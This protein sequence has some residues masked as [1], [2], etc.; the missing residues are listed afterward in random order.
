VTRMT[1]PFTRRRCGIGLLAAL[2][3]SPSPLV[4]QRAPATRPQ[5]V[6]VLVVD[7]MRAD[8][9]DRFQRDWSAGLKRV[10]T[11]GA[12]FTNVAYP[13]LATYT[14][15]GH[16]TIA[17]GTF[18]HL[19]G[20][21]QNAWYDRERGGNMTCTDDPT[22]QGVSYGG[23]ANA[24]GPGR[25]RV[26]TL[27]DT[28]RAQRSSRVVSLAIK[29]RSAIMLAGHGGD[30]V[31]WMPEEDD[32]WQTSTAFS[33][34]PN[35]AMK[36]YVEANRIEAD[37]GK[38][39][40]RTLPPARYPEVDDGEAEAP[41]PGWTTAFPH[42]L[43]D[44]S[45]APGKQFYTLWQHS[46][47]A[48]EYVG[49]MAAS[50]AETLQLGQRGTTDLLAISFSSPDLVGHQ[51][52]PNSQEIRDM[53]VRLDRTIGR[54]LKRLD[55][56]LGRDG[57]VVAVSADH[58]VAEIPEQ[59][60]RRGLNAGRLTSRSVNELVQRTVEAVF[61]PG[62]YA[63]RVTTNDVYF[64]PG[65]Y[66]RL[67]REP[68]A[69]EAVE[70]ALTS[71]P[72]IVRVLRAEQLEGSIHSTDPVVRAAALSYVPGRSGDMVLVTRPRWMFSTV[73]TT[74][75]SAT[76]ADQRVPLAFM[77]WGIRPGAYADAATPA[78]L[79]PTLAALVGVSMPTAEGRA[80][81]AALRTPAAH[82]QAGTP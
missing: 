52:G 8:Y 77:G 26:P 23:H 72:G 39:W 45:G 15:A 63:A 62:Q 5:L 82:R 21:F 76:A 75:G 81:K 73:G 65:V 20:L 9:V 69:L 25:L 79:A 55:D 29:A 16:A 42:P 28:M 13:Y 34:A 4:G 74:H 48:D 57:Y 19:H 37:Y 56:R 80:L 70:K 10:F 6:V 1:H 27:A 43:V 60:V 67:R 49:R 59:Q 32:G 61:G 36:A 50:L 66:D 47:F 46:P 7:Q 68:A 11:T 41:P 12:R 40:R 64:R 71:L 54:L 3:L 38:V 78:D 51:Y 30:L 53:Y 58:G 2:L 18:P 35:A 44:P 33:A 22:V 14:C 31:S 24:D 17:T